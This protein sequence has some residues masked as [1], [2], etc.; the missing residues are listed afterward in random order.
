MHLFSKVRDK[1]YTACVCSAVFHGSETWGLNTSILERLHRN[2]HAMIRW[3]CGTKDRDETF[4]VSL[5]QKAGIK[6]IT[7]ALR[8]GRL[9]WYGHAQRARSCVESVTDLTL[10]DP[11]WYWGLENMVWMC[12]DWYQWMWSNWRWPTRQMLRGPVFGAACCC[13]PNWMGHRQHLNLNWIWW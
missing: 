1:V 11:R 6:D 10:P 12:Q 9:W 7:A 13:Q 5:R 8:N 2:D 4:S 3:I